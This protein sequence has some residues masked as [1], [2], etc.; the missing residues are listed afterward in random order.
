MEVSFGMMGISHV[1]EKWSAILH[2]KNVEAKIDE[3]TRTITSSLL[4]L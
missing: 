3:T 4:T 1:R 2:I